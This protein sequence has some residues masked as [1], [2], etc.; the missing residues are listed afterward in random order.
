M[1]ALEADLSICKDHQNLHG[2]R[3]GTTMEKGQPW[4]DKYLTS[5]PVRTKGR[6]TKAFSSGEI[7]CA[8]CTSGHGKG[9]NNGRGRP[10]RS[11]LTLLQIQSVRAKCRVNSWP[12]VG[13]KGTVYIKQDIE[14][15]GTGKLKKGFIYL[16]H[17]APLIIFEMSSTNGYNKGDQKMNLFKT[18]LWETWFTVNSA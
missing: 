6:K 17:L 11:H 1:R 2:R 3:S 9:E 15:T 8:I 13:S 12:G 10:D 5:G 4:D 14:I 18:Q 16:V 7:S